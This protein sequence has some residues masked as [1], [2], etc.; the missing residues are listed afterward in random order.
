MSFSAWRS[1]SV[2]T[3]VMVRRRIEDDDFRYSDVIG[4]V[5]HRDHDGL[6]LRTRHGEEVTV[7]ADVIATGKVVPPAPVRRPRA[8]PAGMDHDDETGDDAAGLSP[9]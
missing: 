7:P 1:W 2:G 8:A 9:Q 3:R 5:V 6:V 4:E